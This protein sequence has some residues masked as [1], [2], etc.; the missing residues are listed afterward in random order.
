MVFHAHM[1]NPRA[2]LEDSMRHGMGT[3]WTAG[4]PWKLVNDSIDTRFNY[5]VPDSAKRAGWRARTVRGLV[6]RTR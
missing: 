5:N 3:I 1:L 4:M 2:F 6:R